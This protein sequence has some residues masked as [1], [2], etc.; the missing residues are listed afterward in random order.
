MSSEQ[1]LVS[2]TSGDES[3]E[4]V[5]KVS[6][7]E[8]MYEIYAKPLHRLLQYIVGTK[9]RYF[10][11]FWALRDVNF[12][13][14]KGETFGIIGRNGAG[15]T[16]LLQCIAGT[17]TKTGGE[18]ESIGQMTALLEL[19]SGFNPEF[20]GRENVYMNGT[21]LGIPRKEMDKRISSIEEFADI[22]QFFERPVKTYSK[23]M[24]ARLAFSVMANIDPDIL[25]IDEALAVG[26]AIFRHRCMLRINQLKER[27]A[28]ILYVAHD[29]GA[30]RR[31]C[32]RVLWLDD[33]KM[34]M[35]GPSA[36][37]VEAYLENQFEVVS[38]SSRRE[39]IEQEL[40]GEPEVGPKQPPVVQPVSAP[41]VT[42]KAVLGLGEAFPPAES[43]IPGGDYRVGDRLV[44]ILGVGVYN[45]QRKRS[46]VIE[47]GGDMYLRLTFVNRSSDDS[48]GRLQT[49]WTLKNIRGDDISALHSGNEGSAV[50]ELNPSEQVTVT[51]RIRI[52][53]L[54]PGSYAVTMG[55]S[56]LDETGKP[57][58]ADR[59]VNVAVVHVIAD[60]VVQGM[61]RFQ[62]D[63]DYHCSLPSEACSS[64]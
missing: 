29:A 60:R 49:G 62:T 24:Y 31:L 13:V 51:W 23:G 22:G 42:A 45:N 47:A 28:T 58:V 32:D 26:D 19:G 39:P 46:T 63:V 64:E 12:E 43:T 40:L 16:T 44:E 8:K 57:C 3:R 10:T 27:G 25:I 7:V 48:V 20:S 11:E 37:V 53:Y 52:P 36:E 38:E 2:D 50:P 34:R 30:V 33:G 41:K 21:V 61:I 35:I 17:L 18:I 14:Q 56:V 5:L 1:Q 9:K 59:I 6:G 15:K 54:Q 4:V 55:V